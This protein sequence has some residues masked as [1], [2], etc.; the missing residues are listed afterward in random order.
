MPGLR[1]RCGRHGQGAARMTVREI[2]RLSV[3]LDTS[4]LLSAEAAFLRASATDRLRKRGMMLGQMF[5]DTEMG[6][7]KAERYASRCRAYLPDKTAELVVV[8]R[9]AVP[10]L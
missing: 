7:D 8:R 10:W 4:S 3:T 1:L 2:H 6:R 9:M 5:D